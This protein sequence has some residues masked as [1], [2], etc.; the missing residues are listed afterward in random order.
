MCDGCPFFQF[1]L[2]IFIYFSF[3]NKEMTFILN[4]MSE[5]FANRKIKIKEKS[6]NLILLY[7]R[8]CG[9]VFF[10]IF[11]NLFSCIFQH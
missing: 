9:Y 8:C 7:E 1:R 10:L 2:L 3:L 6:N 11:D 5:Y 4:I